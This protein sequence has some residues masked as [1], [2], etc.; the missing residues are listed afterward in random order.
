M[1]ANL[2]RFLSVK[3]SGVTM[4]YHPLQWCRSRPAG[5]SFSLHVQKKIS[6]ETRPP[7][8]HNCLRQSR[9]PSRH[10][11]NPRRKK[12]SLSLRQ[13]FFVFRINF[14]LFGG[15]QREDGNQDQSQK[16]VNKKSNR[17]AICCS[18]DIICS[19]TPT[20]GTI[21]NFVSSLRAASWPPFLDLSFF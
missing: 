1:L 16:H 5:T 8:I 17:L 10:K 21:L 18:Q 14:I 11:I 2:L 9:I 6:K 12:N 20:I 3:N 19:T 7:F 13:F 4:S 15:T